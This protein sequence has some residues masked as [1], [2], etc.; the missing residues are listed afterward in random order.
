[1]IGKPKNFPMVVLICNEILEI[2][3]AGYGTKSKPHD[4]WKQA[5]HLV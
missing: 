1:M 4:Y 5:Q 3:I 2:V